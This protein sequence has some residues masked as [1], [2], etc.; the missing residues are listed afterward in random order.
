M[1]RMKSIESNL[2]RTGLFVAVFLCIL[3]LLFRNFFNHGMLVYTDIF[4]TFNATPSWDGVNLYFSAWNPGSLGSY[5]TNMFFWYS[6]ASLLSELGLLGSAM[7]ALFVYSFLAFSFLVLIL[8]IRRVSRSVLVQITSPMVYLLSP[9]LFVEIFNGSG[10]FTVFAMTP[11]FAYLAYST[12]IERHGVSAALLAATLCV[13]NFFMPF[14]LV[15]ALP[16]VLSAMIVGFFRHPNLRSISILLAFFGLIY[17]GAVL[18]NAPYYLANYSNFVSVLPHGSVANSLDS[19]ILFNYQWETPFRTWLLT[20]SGLYVRYSGFYSHWYSNILILLP[21]LSI[22][23]LMKKAPNEKTRHLKQFAGLLLLSTY[24]VTVEI[25]LGTLLFLFHLFP[26][27]Y[28]DNYPE[29]FGICLD[30]SY[31]ILIPILLIEFS[32]LSPSARFKSPVQK[33]YHRILDSIDGHTSPR[34]MT[35]S[36]IVT[37]S[38]VM[39]I[40]IILIVPAGFYVSKGNFELQKIDNAMGVPSQWNVTAPASFYGIYDFLASHNGLNGERPLI[41]PYPGQ[42][43]QDQFRDFYPFLFNQPEFTGNLSQTFATAGGGVNS[44]AFVTSVMDAFILNETDNIGIPLG[45]ASVKYIIVDKTLGFT[46]APYWTWGSLVGSPQAFIHLLSFQKDITKVFENQ[47]IVAYENL[48]YRPFVQ[49]YSGAMLVSY[50]N[51]TLPSLMVHRWDLNSSSMDQWQPFIYPSTVGNTIKKINNSYY[52]TSGDSGAMNLTFFDSADGGFVQAGTTGVI[53]VAG[54]GMNSALFPA[55]NAEYSLSYTVKYKGPTA[56]G[57]FVVLFGRNQN[58]TILWSLPA[59]SD[60]L[61]SEHNTYASMTVKSHNFN[62]KAMNNKTRFVSIG[63]SFQFNVSNGNP[64]RLIFS[65]FSLYNVPPPSTDPMLSSLL[66][67]QLPSNF[68][69]T[70]EAVVPTNI[71]PSTFGGD[72]IR[73]G[74]NEIVYINPDSNYLNSNNSSSYLYLMP[75]L[76]QVGRSVTFTRTPAGVE[77]VSLTDMGKNVSGIIPEIELISNRSYLLA[78]G[79]GIIILGYFSNGTIYQTTSVHVNSTRLTWY[80][81]NIGQTDVKSEIMMRL[82]GNITINAIFATNLKNSKT[83]Q[84]GA[85]NGVSSQTSLNPSIFKIIVSNNSHVIFL[86]QS[87]YPGWILSYDGFKDTSILGFGWGNLFVVNWTP[88]NRQSAWRGTIY[89]KSES[90]RLQTIDLQAGSWIVW[91]MGVTISYCNLVDRSTILV[92]RKKMRHCLLHDFRKR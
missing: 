57:A 36:K 89:L 33:R 30:I 49:G 38:F 16:I 66:S 88:A 35:M 32:Q 24:L 86:S 25:H 6:I 3:L 50:G 71:S 82:S 84:E 59:Y 42:F 4:N 45:V 80:H 73:A 47:T 60:I 28:A 5:N 67:T 44:Q 7:E 61:S 68:G 40:V 56:N 55:R 51:M 74:F 13:S 31:A 1:Q 70:Q 29:E 87:Y 52:F 91:F 54:I 63:V 77:G 65:N 53:D 27:F 17:G 92:W 8:L 76:L 34:Q 10:G 79:N 58:G 48:D 83:P 23:A 62:P 78:S 2:I 72:R 75:Y 22:I 69:F 39:V 19:T 37:T 15:W 81:I 9:M 12:F 46:G 85:F 14:T 11:A 43:G 41:L 18:L 64:S 26:I 21:F 90:L 20:G